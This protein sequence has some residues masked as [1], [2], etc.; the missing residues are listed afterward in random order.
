MNLDALIATVLGSVTG[1][2]LLLS[3]LFWYRQR[4]QAEDEQRFRKTILGLSSGLKVPEDPLVVKA[5]QEG[6]K[7]EEYLHLL[8]RFKEATGTSTER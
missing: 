5:T 4:Q 6:L 1:I 7:P 2:C 8:Q 3:F